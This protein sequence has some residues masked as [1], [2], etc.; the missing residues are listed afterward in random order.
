[1]LEETTYLNVLLPLL[2]GTF[3]TS[4]GNLM[5]AIQGNS[6]LKVYSWIKFIPFQ[7]KLALVR[8]CGLDVAT[9]AIIKERYGRRLL[10]TGTLKNRS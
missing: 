1:M 6:S 4:F 5:L 9:V 2:R 8:K 10:D 3:N 7:S